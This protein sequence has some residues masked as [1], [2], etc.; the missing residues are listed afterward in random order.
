MQLLESSAVDTA[1]EKFWHLMQLESYQAGDG[2]FGK[3]GTDGITRAGYESIYVRINKCVARGKWEMAEAKFDGLQ[4]WELDVIRFK[5]NASILN[6]MRKIRQMFSQNA[7]KFVQSK[8]WNLLFQL[9]DAD[10]SGASCLVYAYR[11]L[12]VLL[13]L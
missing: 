13:K 3:L 4:D 1:I 8:G 6:W 2:P 10:G 5:E 11:D 9:Y 12:L 7:E